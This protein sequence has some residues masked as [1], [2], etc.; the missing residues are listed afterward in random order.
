MCDLN[1]LAITLVPSSPAEASSITFCSWYLNYEQR[2][3]YNFL[4]HPLFNHIAD[5]FAKFRTG[6]WLVPLG[7]STEID[8]LNLLDTALI[9]EVSLLLLLS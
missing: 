4:A 5:L 8:Y 7:R 9:H 3:E 1:T 2:K 6:E